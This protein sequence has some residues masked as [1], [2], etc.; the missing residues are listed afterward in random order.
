VSAFRVGGCGKEERD[1]KAC[2]RHTGSGPSRHRPEVAARRPPDALASLL[3]PG[4][5][6]FPSLPP[7][8]APPLDTSFL[9]PLPLLSSFPPSLPPSLPPPS[10][11]PPCPTVAGQLGGRRGPRLPRE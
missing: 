11:P 3:P 7:P 5:F 2:A 1:H 4:R 6:P 8:R 10:R 9:S